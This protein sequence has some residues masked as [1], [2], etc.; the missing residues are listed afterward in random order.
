MRAG[1]YKTEKKGLSFA[2][3]EGTCLNYWVGTSTSVCSTQYINPE[4]VTSHLF[5]TSENLIGCFL[6]ATALQRMITQAANG[7]LPS[8]THCGLISKSQTTSPSLGSSISG[9]FNT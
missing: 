8:F 3:G 2:K 5:L 7:I 6:N 9:P 4:T 1:G